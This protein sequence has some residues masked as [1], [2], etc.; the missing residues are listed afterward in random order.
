[1]VPDMSIVGAGLKHDAKRA[2]LVAYLATL[3]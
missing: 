3:H 2:E 1:M